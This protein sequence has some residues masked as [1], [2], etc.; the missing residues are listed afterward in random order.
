M[1]ELESACE[2]L[3]SYSINFLSTIERNILRARFWEKSRQVFSKYINVAI[4]HQ[5]ATIVAMHKSRNVHA[6]FFGRYNYAIEECA[7]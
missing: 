5:I 4:K 1:C 2:L 6:L 7:I 3:I